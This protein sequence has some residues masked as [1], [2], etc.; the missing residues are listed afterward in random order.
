MSTVGTLSVRIVGDNSDLT[1]KLGVSTKAVAA[2]GAAAVTAAVAATAALVKAGLQSADA[3]VKLARSLDGTI[4]GLQA[5]D[6]AANRAGVSSGELEGALSRLNQNLGRAML[7]GGPAA[8]ALERLGLNAQQLSALDVDERMAAIADQV[9]ALGLNSQETAAILRDLGIRQASVVNLMRDGGDAI[10]E[11][12][13]RLAEY[14]LTMNNIDARKIE[15]ANDAMGEFSVIMDGVSQKLAAKFAPAIELIATKFADAAAEGEGIGSGVDKAYEMIKTSAIFI[16]NAIDGVA[17]TFEVA[18]KAGAAFALGVTKAILELANAIINGPT[19]AVNE[20]INL[21]NKIPML[22]IGEIG[23]TNFGE[24]IAQQ[25]LIVDGALREA[26]AD[27]QN[28][29]LRPLAGDE[30]KKL[31]DEAEV[32]AEQIAMA[33]EAGMNNVLGDESIMSKALGGSAEDQE[34]LEQDLE[35]LREHYAALEEIEYESFQRRK[36]IMDEALANNLLTEEEYKQ[37]AIQNAMELNNALENLEGERAKNT[38]EGWK[39]AFSGLSS[40]MSS[41]SKK[42]FAIGKAAALAEA[43]VSGWGAAT[44]AW[45]KGMKTGGYP[46]AIAWAAGSIA[47]TGAQIS[48][49]RNTQIGGGGSASGGGGGSVPTA[50]QPVAAPTAATGTTSGQVVQIA[51]TGEIFGREQVRNLISQINESIADGAVLRLA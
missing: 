31:L 26:G 3:Q 28:T 29:L 48:S 9:K 34:R 15:A 49:L 8:D 18:G 10:R 17:R 25:L 51:L 38:L 14:G 24:D 22:E 45:E 1:K 39:S 47:K 12:K 19:K 30:F 16:I 41:E 44:A 46:L 27:I 5:L 21:M 50:P 7:E 37:L 43:I 2:F 36:E 40:L 32:N 42:L 13:D 20:L 35:R 11:S 33:A 4:T 23:L 6:R